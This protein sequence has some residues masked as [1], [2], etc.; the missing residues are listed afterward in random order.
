MP[1]DTSGAAMLLAV[2][3]RAESQQP[4]TQPKEPTGILQRLAELIHAEIPDFADDGTA[5]AKPTVEKL[6]TILDK[7]YNEPSLDTTIPTPPARIRTAKAMVSHIHASPVTI[8]YKWGNAGFEPLG[9]AALD[10][11]NVEEF[12]GLLIARVVQEALAKTKCPPQYRV[13][14]FNSTKRYKPNP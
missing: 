2:A 5:Y 11:E 10:D 1:D 12:C 7:T 3:A 4:N 14:T 13:S 8:M 6:K 9:I